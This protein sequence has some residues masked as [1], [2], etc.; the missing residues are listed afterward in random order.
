[1]SNMSRN[2]ICYI[3]FILLAIASCSNERG[4]LPEESLP[5]DSLREGDLV[6]RRG[7]NMTSNIIIAKDSYNYSHIGILHKSDSGWCVIHAVNDEHDFNGDFD[8]VKIDR[9]ETF[10]SQNRASAGAIA[11]NFVSDS[12]ANYMTSLALQHVIDSTRFDSEFILNDNS[13][14]YCTEFIHILH[15]AIGTDITEGRR[16]PVGL[17]GFPNEI[18]FP[19]DVLKNKNLHIYF[20]Y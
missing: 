4:I 14:L 15:K 20:I 9:I 6:F 12:I 2:L 16:T 7:R 11:H 18:I 5:Y 19:S 1:M 3:T 17:V 10:F 13:A 8:R